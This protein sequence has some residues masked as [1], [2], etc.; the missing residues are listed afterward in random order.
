MTPIPRVSLSVGGGRALAGLSPRT[1]FDATAAAW[2]D[3]G[4]SVDLGRWLEASA[5]Y[6]RDLGLVDTTYGRSQTVSGGLALRLPG[7]QG[8]NVAAAHGLTDAA[9]RWSVSVGVGLATASLEALA[10]G[11]WSCPASDTAGEFVR[12]P[13]TRASDGRTRIGACARAA[14]RRATRRAGRS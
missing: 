1:A 14:R 3:A 12:R 10:R 7:V 11:H 4:L 5:G 6:G 2:S 8:L 9:P 13:L